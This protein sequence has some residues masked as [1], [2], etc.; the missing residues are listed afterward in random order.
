MS[1][2]YYLWKKL[3]PA[4]LNKILGHT[5]NNAIL[6][7]LVSHTRGVILNVC[8][9]LVLFL[10]PLVVLSLLSPTGHLVKQVIERPGRRH[11]RAEK[12]RG[13][14]KEESHEVMKTTPP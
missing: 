4:C 2:L 3:P 7:L 1:P 13:S 6:D 12:K 9:S 14:K 5:H 8:P 11:W 10:S